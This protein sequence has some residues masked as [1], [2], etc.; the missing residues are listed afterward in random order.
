MRRPI[1]ITWKL[2]PG[3]ESKT[4]NAPGNPGRI[5]NWRARIRG[6]GAYWNRKMAAHNRLAV[7]DRVRKAPPAMF[8]CQKER[9]ESLGRFFLAATPRR[10]AARGGPAQR[11]ACAARTSP[12]RP[13]RDPLLRSNSVCFRSL[14]S[15]RPAAG[16]RGARCAPSARCSPSAGCSFLLLRAFLLAPRARAALARLTIGSAALSA[17][18]RRLRAFRAMLGPNAR[19]THPFE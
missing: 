3:P 13:G 10:R 6:A 11:L 4:G 5:T 15:R 9:S 16:F 18:Q 7:W 19:R 12:P 8:A 14:R 17:R 2:K 1:F